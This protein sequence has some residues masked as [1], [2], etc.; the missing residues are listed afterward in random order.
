MRGVK[1]DNTC[2]LPHM[3][4]DNISSKGELPISIR[5]DLTVIA[6]ARKALDGHNDT[7]PT[8]P[9]TTGLIAVG[10]TGVVAAI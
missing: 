7:A 4:K 3:E 2:N 8:A 6:I 1:G 5:C 10:N 9:T